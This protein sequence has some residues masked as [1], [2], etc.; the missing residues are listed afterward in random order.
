MIGIRRENKNR[1]ERRV[2]LTPEHVA[3]LTS[4]HGVEVCLQPSPIRAFADEAYRRS[5]GRVLEDL[6]GCRVILG[7]KE[8]PLDRIV[9]GAVHVFFAHVIKGQPYNMPMLRR[10]MELGCTLVEYERIRDDRGKRLIFFGRHA[11]IAGMVD[12]LWAL[13]RRLA[14]E[15][16]DTPFA[17]CR[18]AHEY[19]DLEEVRA[20]LR[21]V[22]HAV[23]HE[24]VPGALHPLVF[25]FTG[26]GNVS[27]GAQ[28][29]FSLLPFEEVNPDELR[30]LAASADLP[31]NVVFK[32]VFGR[33]DRVERVGGG[34]VDEAE[35]SAHPELYRSAMGRYLPYLTVLVNGIYWDPHH[36]RVVSAQDLRD[37][38]SPGASPRLRV[39]GDISCD[40]LGSIEATVKLTTPGDPVY[41][42]EPGTGIATS[43]VAG[44]GPVVL[45]VDN[46][47]CELPVDA[48]QHFGDALMRFVPVLDRC[49]WER[50]FE[51]LSLP[52]E[53]RRAVVV[54]R[55]RLAPD[56]LYLDRHL[57]ESARLGR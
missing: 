1:W 41:V 2:P 53:I 22:A 43:G 13:G 17:G 11:G 23:R 16:I 30:G 51:S 40:L 36:P 48:S 6:A 50:P 4:R 12:C 31:R 42:V 27:R 54:H 49:D 7:V 28:E 55:G 14:W 9:P 18:L 44:R 39:I 34:R 26:S 35:L 5:G 46:L 3:E 29:I 57:A 8:I 21:R 32:T 25:G 56:Y 37:L 38:W 10:L 45:A 15:R 47:P 52:P 33:R 24:G 19:G 20:H